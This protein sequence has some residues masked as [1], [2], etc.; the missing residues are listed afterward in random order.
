[1]NGGTE[2]GRFDHFSKPKFMCISQDA[3]ITE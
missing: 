3:T 1:M 2:L